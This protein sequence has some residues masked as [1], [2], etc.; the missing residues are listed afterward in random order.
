VYKAG[1]LQECAVVCA[2]VAWTVKRGVCM[3]WVPLCWVRFLTARQ[4]VPPD[5][6]SAKSGQEYCTARLEN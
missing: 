1:T 4:L 5:H 6:S 2:A 3:L